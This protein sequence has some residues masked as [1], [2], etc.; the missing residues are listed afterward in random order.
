MSINLNDD[1]FNQKAGK[2][3]FNGGNAGIVEAVTV[4]LVKRL[5]M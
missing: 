3:I 2:A 5:R 1:S 4:S